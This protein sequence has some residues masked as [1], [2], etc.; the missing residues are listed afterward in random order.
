MTTLNHR[1]AA[2][3]FE[4]GY[5]HKLHIPHPLCSFLDLTKA[6]FISELHFWGRHNIA[7]EIDPD[8]WVIRTQNQ[9]SARLGISTKQVGRIAAALEKLTYVESELKK[10]KGKTQTRYRVTERFYEDYGNFIATRWDTMSDLDEAPQSDKTSDPRS[11]TMSHQ[12]SDTMS[13][14]RSDKTS[15]PSYIEDLKEDSFPRGSLEENTPLAP[16]GGN[17]SIEDELCSKSEESGIDTSATPPSPKSNPSNEVSESE[18]DKSSAAAAK[19]DEYMRLYN[20]HKPEWFATLRAWNRFRRKVVNDLEK[21][22][23]GK[24]AAQECM[25]NALRFAGHHEWFRDKVSMGFDNLSRESKLH[26]MNLSEKWLE[27]E[28][29]P[30]GGK[31]T[32]IGSADAL[33]SELGRQLNRLQILGVVHSAYGSHEGAIASQ[34]SLAELSDYVAWLQQ[35]APEALRGAA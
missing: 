31:V 14:S 2:L 1:K 11:D 26:W 17:T 8:G 16:Q 6:A 13:D 33:R 10:L 15:D 3:T 23:G 30:D 24:K 19:W 21:N 5:K 12:R 22:L 9:W 28:M 25:I 18:K 34:L 20:E 35:Q 7:E 29:A 32:P 4:S 27:L